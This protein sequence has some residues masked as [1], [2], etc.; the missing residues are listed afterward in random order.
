MINMIT[1][2]AARPTFDQAVYIWKRHFS[3]AHQ[4]IIAAELGM[5]QG[6]ISETLNGHLHPD[7]K[8]VALG[9]ETKQATLF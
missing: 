2:K 3:G 4:H 6:R 9:K 1:R 5:N 8:N 7:A